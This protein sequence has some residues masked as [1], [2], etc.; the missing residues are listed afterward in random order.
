MADIM[1]CQAWPSNAELIEDCVRLGYIRGDTLDPT[2]GLGVFWKR[3]DQLDLFA[4][5][6]DPVKGIRAGMRL[7]YRALPYKDDSFDTVVFDP[8]Y[9]SPGGR[10]TSGVPEFWERYGMQNTPRTPEG[11]YAYNEEG[12]H[13]AARVLRSGGHL[14]YKSQD[15]ISGGKLRP[16]THWIINDADYIGLEYVDRLELITSPRPQP[17]GRRQLHARRNLS[18]LLVFR[19]P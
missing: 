5:D 8:P 7:D 3:I 4:G 16:V 12:A 2:Y 17:K 13:E 11:L 15:Y 6:M 18:T 9:V 14:L 10:S 19:K 1:A